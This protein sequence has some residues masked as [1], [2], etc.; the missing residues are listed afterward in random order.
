MGYWMDNAM[1]HGKHIL[2]DL[3]YVNN[4]KTREHADD[5]AKIISK[6]NIE[7]VYC[8]RVL[9]RIPPAK[10]TQVLNNFPAIN[11]KPHYSWCTHTW[12]YEGMDSLDYASK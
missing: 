6:K 1:E 10:L 8:G 5:L 12:D 9:L 11:A 7:I 4:P 2:V 3:G